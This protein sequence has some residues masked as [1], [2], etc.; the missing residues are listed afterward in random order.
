MSI[1]K[2]IKPIW[3]DY[4]VYDYKY[5]IFCKRQN[6]RDDKRWVVAKGLAGQGQGINGGA[7][8]IFRIVKLFCM[9]L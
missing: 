4:I 9:I 7:K 8:G 3:K 6:F 2:R 5:V 1:A